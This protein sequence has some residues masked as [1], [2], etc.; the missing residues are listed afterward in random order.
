QEIAFHVAVGFQG[1]ALLVFAIV[2]G[3]EFWFEIS[4]GTKQRLATQLHGAVFAIDPVRDAGVVGERAYQEDRPFAWV[5]GS[6]EECVRNIAAVLLDVQATRGVDA[7]RI[8]A[9]GT[10][11]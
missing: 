8:F 10:G 6:H 3:L 4:V 9:V 7:P 11:Y 5:V 1:N 2:A